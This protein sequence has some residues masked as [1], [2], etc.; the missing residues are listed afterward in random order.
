MCGELA[1]MVERLFSMQEVLG[2]HAGGQYIN[3][4]VGI[5]FSVVTG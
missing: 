3:A 1:Q 2:W 4:H 5:F